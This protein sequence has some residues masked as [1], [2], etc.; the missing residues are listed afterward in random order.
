MTA[1]SGAVALAEARRITNRRPVVP[2]PPTDRGIGLLS[3][4]AFSPLP[5]RLIDLPSIQ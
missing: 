3:L 4:K 5:F 2:V 1:A